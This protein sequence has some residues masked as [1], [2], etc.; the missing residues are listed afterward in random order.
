MYKMKKY[1][2]LLN[3]GVSLLSW[4]PFA[5][6]KFMNEQG[7]VHVKNMYIVEQHIMPIFNFNIIPLT[8]FRFWKGLYLRVISRSDT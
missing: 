3:C 2:L 1:S 5:T 8:F 7:K 6:S 4:L